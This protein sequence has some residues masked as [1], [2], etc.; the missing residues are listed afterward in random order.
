MLHIFFWLP[1]P[2][3]RNTRSIQK[4]QVATNTTS[5]TNEL[6]ARVKKRKKCRHVPAPEWKTGR[7][8]GEHVLTP[9][10]KKRRK[11]CRRTCVSKSPPQWWMI[12]HR[13]RGGGDRRLSS[14]RKDKLFYF[15][16]VSRFLSMFHDRQK[17]LWTWNFCVTVMS[18]CWTLFFL[19]K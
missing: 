15:F 6:T 12:R 4:L 18:N 14:I 8:A 3:L 16:L 5:G 19:L 13:P 9:E 1:W 7:N 2:G 11:K 10:W 17:H